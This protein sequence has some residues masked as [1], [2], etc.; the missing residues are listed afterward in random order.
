MKIVV[1]ICLDVDI[2]V[3][4]NVIISKKGGNKMNLSISEV[5]KLLDISKDTLRYYDQLSLVSPNR[6]ENKYRY[7]TQANILELQ[8]IE[9]MKYVGFS[10]KEIKQILMNMNRCT[11]IDLQDTKQLVENQIN[12]I[13]KTIKVYEDIL[14]LMNNANELL[15]MK[16]SPIHS[17][18]IQYK[19]REVFKQ[20]KNK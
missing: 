12:H 16:E 19:V 18:Q 13:K 14:K 17:S 4:S 11:G 10:L 9:V 6:N 7:Y 5:S 15:D 8:Y 3:Y 20:L 1:F 2:R